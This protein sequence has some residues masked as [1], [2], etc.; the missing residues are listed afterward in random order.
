MEGVQLDKALNNY[1]LRGILDIIL[2]HA[3]FI[4]DD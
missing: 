1:L 4:I 3:T 2:E